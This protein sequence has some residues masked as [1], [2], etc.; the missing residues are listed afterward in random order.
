MAGCRGATRLKRAY[1]A[2]K[3]MSFTNIGDLTWDML[4]HAGVRGCNVYDKCIF[5]LSTL[6]FD[7]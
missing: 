7:I 5:S 6:I 4:L 3:M 2:Q 1:G